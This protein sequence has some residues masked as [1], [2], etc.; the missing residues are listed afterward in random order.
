VANLR[1]VLY[2]AKKYQGLG[3]D[4]MD[5]VQEGNLGLMHAIEKFDHTRGYQ[6]ST[7][8]TWWIR[9]YITRALA[10]QARTIHVPLYKIEEIKRLARVRRRLMLQESEPTLEEL[11]KQMDI[12][13]ER[14]IS[15]LSMTQNTVSLD[16]PCRGDDPVPF[17]DILE[18]E[19]EGTPEHVVMSQA[20]QEH[21]RDMLTCLTPR[22]RRVLELRYGLAGEQE[23]SLHQ[24]ERK[25]GISHEAVRQ[26]EIRALGKLE[27]LAATRTLQDFLK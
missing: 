22:E 23:H 6:F 21:V 17:S 3:V 5:L 26:N 16:M 24:V 27:Q 2:N 13:V 11:A 20:L 7:Y 1:L 18:D 19:T 10:E 9:H 15:L 14:V 8:A 4:L 12:S 25:L